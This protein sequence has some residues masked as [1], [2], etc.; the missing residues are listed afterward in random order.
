MSDGLLDKVDKDGYK[1]SVHK[2]DNIVNDPSAIIDA[3]ERGQQ[4]AGGLLDRVD[5][6][7][8][9]DSNDTQSDVM[10]ENLSHDNS[11][12]TSANSI[13]STD[14]GGTLIGIFVAIILPFFIVMWAGM[15]AAMPL[16]II[17]GVAIAWFLLGLRN[18]MDQ[19]T[20][21][22]ISGSSVIFVAVMLAVTPTL[23][24]TV[25]TGTMSFG[26]IEFSEDGSEFDVKVRQ[27]GGSG[28]HDA[29]VSIVRNG[30]S[31]YDS[32]HTFQIDSSDGLGDYGSFT[33]SVDSVYSGNALGSSG[34]EYTIDVTV[35]SQKW[36]NNLDS[37]FMTRTVTEG[38]TDVTPVF[39][40]EGSGQSCD[41]GSVRC[42]SGVSLSVWAGLESQNS[43]LALPW[44][45]FNFTASMT[46]PSGTVVAYP[47]VEV[48]TTSASWDSEGGLYGDGTAIM[49]DEGY[50]ILQLEGDAEQ[51]TLSIVSRD[52]W[53]GDEKGCYTF[54][55]TITQ[56]P[57]WGEETVTASSEHSF[58]S[59][60]GSETWLPGC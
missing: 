32:T 4:S 9:S 54:T 7:S 20:S 37:N 35:G 15:N 45:N 16:V 1:D 57:F 17:G 48:S 25:V 38:Q 40:G 49:G 3:Y 19:G 51:E 53:Q 60:D 22:I 43:P 2:G 6:D 46:G 39:I 29:I 41:D 30:A 21:A 14:F 8:S 23:L 47:T 34:S 44:A 55:V 52:M 31:V 24:G 50:A 13:L 5:A 59:Q 10:A 26:G 42:V 33:I 18:P 12:N 36:S 58:Q 28:S 11:S 56:D 27:N